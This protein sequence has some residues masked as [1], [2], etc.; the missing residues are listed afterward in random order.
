MLQHINGHTSLCH[1]V[2][3]VTMSAELKQINKPLFLQHG[4]VLITVSSG[5]NWS[6]VDLN[7]CMVLMHTS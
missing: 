4:H 2:A 7:I 6:V 5:L 3:L 1:F